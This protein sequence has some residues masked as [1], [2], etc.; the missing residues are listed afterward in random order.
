MSQKID[1]RI[2]LIARQSGFFHR[3]IA[4]RNNSKT[5]RFA[6]QKFLVI[7][8][9]LDR[10]TNSMTKIEKRAFAG[11]IMLVFGHDLRFYLNVATDQRREVLE[12]DIL[13]GGEHFR[14]GDDRVLDDLGEALI[15]LA[16]RQGLQNID[17]VN[18]ECRRMN[19]ADQIFPSGCIHTRLPA[20]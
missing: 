13:K 7:T 16:A 1:N 4:G 10:M 18:Y 8:G 14:V 11:T 5:D 6:V 9:A 12:I 15:E 3:D 17:I 20:D 19:R 2:A